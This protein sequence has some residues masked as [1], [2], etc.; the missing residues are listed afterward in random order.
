MTNSM[1]RHFKKTLFLLAITTS[2][3]HAQEWRPLLDQNLTHWEKWLGRPHPSVQGLPADLPLEADGKKKAPLGLNN[4][5]KNVFSVKM[6]DGEPVLHITGEIWGGLTTLESF[7][8]F[9]LRTQIKWGEAKWQPRLDRVRD[10]GILYHCTG[11]HGVAGGNWKKSLEFQVQEKDMGDFW[12][13]GGTVAEIRASL[14]DGKYFFNPTAAP[15]RFGYEAEGV[16]KSSVAHLPG[17]FEKPY[18][19]W[20]TLDLYVLGADAIHVVNGEVVLTL[21]NGTA[22]DITTK[23]STPLTAGQLQIQSE[24]AECYYRRME[25]TPLKEFPASLK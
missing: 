19:E 11:P 25:I 15:L 20:N 4:D 22:I 2:P 18:G 24:S 21:K 6:Q 23:Q 5:P 14:T 3:S 12:Q 7:S 10:N 17:D 1:R 8:N 9:H 16:I 13:V